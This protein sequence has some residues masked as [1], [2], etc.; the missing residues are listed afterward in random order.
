MLV[1]L[2]FGNIFWGF[3]FPRVQL[4]A[5]VEGSMWGE[6]C[7]VEGFTLNTD[8]KATALSV[9]RSCVDRG[10]QPG[11]Q[12]LTSWHVSWDPGQEG[13]RDV[14]SAGIPAG[15]GLGMWCPAQLLAKT[16]GMGTLSLSFLVLLPLCSL[17]PH[18]PSRQLPAWPLAS[19][20]QPRVL[21]HKMPPSSS[22]LVCP[23]FP[24]AV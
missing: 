6:L 2:M 22:F 15:K 3:C 10:V 13:T 9:Q 7:S 12:L 1:L 18:R 8:T 16:N 4:E 5:R 24:D 11:A 23:A 21:C 20:V 14:L 17:G 19:L